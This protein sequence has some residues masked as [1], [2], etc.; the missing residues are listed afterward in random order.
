MTLQSI[1]PWMQ[2][3]FAHYRIPAEELE[4]LY[5]DCGSRPLG[6]LSAGID[7]EGRDFFTVYYE[8]QPQQ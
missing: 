2:R 5:R 3:L 6:H 4:S 7:R 8:N 1:Y